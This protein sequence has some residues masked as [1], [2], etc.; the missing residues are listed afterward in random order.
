MELTGSP[1]VRTSEISVL[2]CPKSEARKCLV[3]YEV[4]VIVSPDH[5]LSDSRTKASCGSHRSAERPIPNTKPMNDLMVGFEI[6][7]QMPVRRH[8]DWFLGVLKAI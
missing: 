1:F 2:G 6:K 8:E 4:Q 3:L 5:K 7:Q